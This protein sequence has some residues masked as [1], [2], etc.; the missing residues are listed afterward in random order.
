[1]INEKESMLDEAAEQYRDE[2]I[3][4]EIYAAITNHP[5]Q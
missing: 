3:E 4:Y 5:I 1:M 2:Q